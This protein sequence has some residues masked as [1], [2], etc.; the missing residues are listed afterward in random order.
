MEN[1]LGWAALGLVLGLRH[2]MDPDH[3]AAVTAIA[4][5]HR[6][7]VAAVRV[8]AAWGLGH[9]VT[10]LGAGS[11]IVLLNLALPPRVGLALE[12]A[13]GIVLVV[14]GLLNINSPAEHSHAD[15]H[16]HA[17]PSLRAFLV[18]LVHG[19]AGS[20]GVALLVLATVRQPLA[21]C[22]YLLV[23]GLGTIAGM[24]L[25]TVAFA[26]PAAAFAGHVPGSWRALRVATGLV[27][28]AC[29]I[30][31]MVEVGWLGGLFGAAPQWTPH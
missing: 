8:G 10:L 20:A 24:V 2:A 23:F 29:G 16:D 28:A 12:F 22:A 5:R 25:V 11:A 3:V 6:S 26:V 15:G 14:V 21:A 18:G 4:A 13:V 31:V 19:L 1:P 7:P 27:S 30:Y 9:T 17:P